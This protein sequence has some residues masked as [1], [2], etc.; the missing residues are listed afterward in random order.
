MR[1][2]N[3]DPSDYA[4]KSSIANLPVPPGSRLGSLMEEKKLDGL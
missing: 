3:D 4:I 2:W 1:N